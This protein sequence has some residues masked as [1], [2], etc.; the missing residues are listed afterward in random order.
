[1]TAGSVPAQWTPINGPGIPPGDVVF[2]V[3]GSTLTLL[4]NSTSNETTQTY[5]T[6]AMNPDGTYNGALCP[7]DNSAVTYWNDGVCNPASVHTSWTS[8]TFPNGD[9]LAQ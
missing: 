8:T 2:S 7:V 5:A 1:M 6:G 3:S 4:F 9:A